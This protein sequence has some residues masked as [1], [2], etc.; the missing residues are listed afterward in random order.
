MGQIPYT[1]I[2]R[3]RLLLIA[4]LLSA[5]AGAQD[6]VEYRA[7]IGAGGG[8]TTYYG[9]FNS[10]LFKGMQPAGAVLLRITPNPH[11]A[12]RVDAMYTKVKGSA[13]DV[14]TYYEPLRDMNYTFDPP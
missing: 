11:M 2:I 1:Y 14:K 10:K 3:C 8:L 5:T 9:D 7:E 12:F 6:D 4:L 13:S